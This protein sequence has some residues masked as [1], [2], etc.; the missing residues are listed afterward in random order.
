MKARDVLRGDKSLARLRADHDT[1]EDVF[2]R[3]GDDVVDG[4]HLAAVGRVDGHAFLEHLVGDRE[5]LVHDRHRTG[6]GPT[7]WDATASS[8]RGC[9]PA[10][11]P[12]GQ[13]GAPAARCARSASTLPD[14]SAWLIVPIC[15]ISSVKPSISLCITP[16][17][18]AFS[19]NAGS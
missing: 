17:S 5:T 9:A 16:K 7:Q 12:D 18:I 14:T 10:Y 19:P 15:P 8:E 11:A 2:L 13:P 1:V 4:S 6:D 3:R